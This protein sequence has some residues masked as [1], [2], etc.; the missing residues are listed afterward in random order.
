MFIGVLERKPLIIY[1]APTVKAQRQLGIN[2]VLSAEPYIS[3]SIV[4]VLSLGSG[5]QSV[6]RLRRGI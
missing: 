4:E 3:R 6:T 2:R 1:F 5:A